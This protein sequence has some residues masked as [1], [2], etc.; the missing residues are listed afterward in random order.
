M[1]SYE[2]NTNNTILKMDVKNV[3]R[4]NILISL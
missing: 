2:I 3:S 4:R 1:A